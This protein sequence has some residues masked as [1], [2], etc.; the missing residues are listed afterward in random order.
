M[1]P[2]V[3]AFNSNLSFQ[4]S[5]P[6]TQRRFA[7]AR[8]NAN[9]PYGMPSGTSNNTG[10]TYGQ[11][12]EDQRGWSSLPTWA[13][14]IIIGGITALVALGGK[15]AYDR[16]FVNTKPT[17]KALTRKEQKAL[18]PAP[19]GTV[20]EIEKKAEEASKG[21]DDNA[22][23][24]PSSGGS[25]PYYSPSPAPTP[26]RGFWRRLGD[27][28]RITGRRGYRHARYGPGRAYRSIR[29]D[30]N[31]LGNTT[32]GRNLTNKEDWK[33][34]AKWGLTSGTVGTIGGSILAAWGT[35]TMGIFLAPVAACV[36]PA[37]ILFGFAKRRLGNWW[38][39]ADNMP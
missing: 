21:W 1:L 25:G 5:P 17:T 7:F 12:D 11:G 18:P 13:R 8:G 36:F 31:N 26:R 35:P 33:N 3:S 9:S 6:V 14:G 23:G 2:R 39:S 20:A 19:A 37:T 24:S 10:N 15:T 16:Y 22:F 38:R 28:I 34:V 30:V 4:A 29:R 32:T 27:K